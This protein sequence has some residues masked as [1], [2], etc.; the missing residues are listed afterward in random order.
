MAM[1]DLEYWGTWFLPKRQDDKIFGQLIFSN[2]AGIYLKLQGAFEDGDLIEVIEEY[3]REKPPK[4][5][6]ILLGVTTE[7]KLL[8]LH[9]CM[10][11]G[12]ET[13]FGQNTHDQGLR[14]TH[15]QYQIEHILDGAHFSDPAEMVFHKVDLHY[16]NLSD[17]ARL[18]GFRW[19]L[20]EGKPGHLE[21]YEL[22]Y[23]YPESIVGVVP[24]GTVSVHFAFHFSPSAPNNI[25]LSQ[26]TYLQIELRKALTIDGWISSFAYHL[27][28]LLSLA[29]AKPHP[30]IDLFAYSKIEE[31]SDERSRETPIRVVF[32]QRYYEPHKEEWLH[33]GKM[34]FSLQDIKGNFGDILCKW[35]QITDP[36]EFGG[37]CDLFF[38]V[39][40]SPSIYLPHE[41]LNVV[42]AAES[43]HRRRFNRSALPEEE[44]KKRKD[45]VINSA[46][47]ECKGWIEGQFQFRNDLPFRDRINEMVD[48]TIPVIGPLVADREYFVKK[49]KST[50]NLLTHNIH[51]L[52]GEAAK[53]EELFWITKTL[54]YMVHTC[55]LT[56]LG[57]TPKRCAELFSRNGEYQFAKKLA[58]KF[59]CEQTSGIVLPADSN[60]TD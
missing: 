57:F 20:S 10:R 22:S 27:Q 13:R 55:L 44:F 50:R 3:N 46:P 5:F 17:W 26:T 48:F 43:Y 45:T 36:E 60:A 42:T 2:R 51:E 41:F 56:E 29:T 11:V 9:N 38:S 33:P 32:S 34:V 16:Q 35:L 1:D 28:N 23:E 24:N 8:T 31:I 4:Q 21:K 18:W 58:P 59:T 19:Q 37:L 54:T 6:P 39:I 53:D 52:E 47:E 7:N 49:V 15:E 30:I 40:Y 12:V 14:G 25:S